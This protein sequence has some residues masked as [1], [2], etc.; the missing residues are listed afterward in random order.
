MLGNLKYDLAIQA[1]LEN[2]LDL[3][4]EKYNVD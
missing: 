2:E 4:G 3:E 1:G